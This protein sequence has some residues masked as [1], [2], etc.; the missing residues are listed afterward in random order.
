MVLEDYCLTILHWMV[1]KEDYARTEGICYLIN[2]IYIYI[3]FSG[4]PVI[5]KFGTIF[6][7]PFN[8]N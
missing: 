3:K 6:N 4:L 5:D 8:L 2:I 7:F 1:M